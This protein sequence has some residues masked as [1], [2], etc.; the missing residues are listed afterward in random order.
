[1]RQVGLIQLGV[2]VVG[3]EVVRLVIRNRDSWR[4]TYGIDVGYLA[5][6][7][8]SGMLSGPDRLSDDMLAEA[9]AQKERG[10]SL[11]DMSNTVPDASPDALRALQSVQVLGS[12][13]DCA[14]GEQTYEHDLH[15]LEGSFNVILSN[16]A[17]LAVSQERY[18]ALHDA[19]KT[20]SLWYEATVGAGLPVISTLRSL[21]DTGDEVEEVVCCASGTLG[22][23]T[24]ELMH[25]RTYSEAVGRAREL[26][27]TEPDPRDDL[28]GLD[29][30]R[31]ALILARTFGRRL[32]LEDVR[33]E[34][35]LPPL[36]SSLSVP[37]FLQALP[38][39]DSQFRER[40]ERAG[41]DGNSLKYIARVPADGEVT[42]KL[43]EVPAASQIGSLTGPD[44]IFSFRTREYRE[45]PLV[46]IG[47][48]AGP[49]NTA[50]GI[51]SD[52][53]AGARR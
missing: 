36:D 27:Y 1:M 37:E 19:G 22:Y 46:V 17:P 3:R 39:A 2:G 42:V 9:V 29:V 16:K 28:S 53:L 12:V 50:M 15:A 43:E 10:G 41:R 6:L 13:I 18:D 51:L 45:H 25:G 52:V 44:N 5:L 35:L 14:A 21:L 31:K 40:V 48:G 4:E 34:P 47:P 32:E 23:I 8:S 30:A 7:D 20:G 26:G 49:V 33:V 38:S 24:S 11:R